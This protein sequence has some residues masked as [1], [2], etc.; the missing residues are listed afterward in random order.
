MGHLVNALRGDYGLHNA[1]FLAKLPRGL[2]S[3]GE[4]LTESC[5][6][7]KS[8]KGDLFYYQIV[9][10]GGGLYEDVYLFDDAKDALHWLDEQLVW[11]R[12]AI[13]S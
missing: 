8:K 13:E 6:L 4:H 10:F 9:G 3:A 2:P 12:K 5:V 11:I 1:T 7:Y